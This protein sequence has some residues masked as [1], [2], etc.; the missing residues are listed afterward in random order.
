M[1][2]IIQ[3]ILKQKLCTDKPCTSN[4][5]GNQNQNWDLNQNK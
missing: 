1:D 5:S 2:V 4:W 3:D